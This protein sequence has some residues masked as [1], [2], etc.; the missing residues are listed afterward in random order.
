MQ[1]LT[2]FSKRGDKEQVRQTALSRAK[3]LSEIKNW[4]KDRYETLI[5]QRNVM[6]ILCVIGMMGLGW[7]ISKVAELDAQKIFTP[8][9]IE[10]ESKSGI[11]TQVSSQTYAKYTADEAMVR[12]FVNKYILAR[13]NYKAAD[14]SFFYN[15]VVRV[16][17]APDVFQ[18]FVALVS[19]SNTASPINLGASYK[20]E[21]RLKSM[22]LLGKNRI[23][24]RVAV[25]KV[26]QGMAFG[27]VLETAHYAILMD[28]EFLELNLNP[29]ERYINPLG[30]QVK[31]YRREVDNDAQN[32]PIDKSRLEGTNNAP[33]P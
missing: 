21:A 33:A 25:D 22:T 28:Y 15:Q 1:L 18:E 17:S 6:F 11:V 7:S 13:E 2:K 24:V 23:Q 20:L 3:G 12:Y 19:S 26:D 30:F 4:Y 27:R 5:V 14:Y 8:Y 10:V 29:N 16:L 9:V 31:S 32:I